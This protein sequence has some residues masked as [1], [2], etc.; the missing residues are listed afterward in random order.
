MCHKKTNFYCS[1]FAAE[2]FYKIECQ[3]KEN[4]EQIEANSNVNITDQGCIVYDF[5]PKSNYFYSNYTAIDQNSL[6]YEIFTIYNKTYLLKQYY[7]CICYVVSRYPLKSVSIDSFINSLFVK[8]SVWV[9]FYIGASNV[10]VLNCY[11]C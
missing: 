10:Y 3:W 6:L 1:N 7:L 2:V 8:Y 9:Y 11:I 5:N 4:C